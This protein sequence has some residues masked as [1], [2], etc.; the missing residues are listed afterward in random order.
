MEVPQTP[1]RAP[2]FFKCCT[3]P[4]LSMLLLKVPVNFSTCYI[5]NSRNLLFSTKNNTNIIIT[6][7]KME[8]WLGYKC[9]Q[10]SNKSKTNPKII[11]KY[12]H[13]KTTIKDNIRVLQT[14]NDTTTDPLRNM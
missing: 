13:S 11:F 14:T 9:Q 1:A 4:D 5:G 10:F 8:G 12:I 3:V 7:P 6:H 2:F